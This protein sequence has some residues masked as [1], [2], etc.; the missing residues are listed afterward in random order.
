MYH[1]RWPMWDYADSRCEQLLW[2]CS[3]LWPLVLLVCSLYGRELDFYE[4]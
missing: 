1:N 2:I 4:N 3:V